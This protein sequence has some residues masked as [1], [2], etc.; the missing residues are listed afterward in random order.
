[1]SLGVSIVIC[2]HNSAKRLPETLRHLAMQDVGGDVPWEVLLIDNASTDG[3]ADLARSCWPGGAPAEIRIVSE[4]KPGIANARFR[5][6][7]EARHEIVSFLDDDNWAGPRWVRDVADFFERHP[8]A[9]AV[10]GPSVAAFE[11]TPPAWFD[12]IRG[13]YAVGSQ[14]A[15]A[16]DITM[17]PGTLLW[18]AGMSVRKERVLD[19]FAQGFHFLACGGSSLPLR[20]GEDTE[21]SFALRASGGRLFYEPQFRIEH[22]MPAGRLVWPRALAAAGTMGSSSVL[23]DI[24]LLALDGP[25]YAGRSPFKKS[26]AFYLA[27]TIADLLKLLAGHPWQ[28][29]RQPEGSLVALQFRKQRAR[30]GFILMLGARFGALKSQLSKSRWRRQNLELP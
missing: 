22:F 25:G 5:S 29:L 12:A 15:I 28:C 26:R 30:L 2:C 8:D 9:S 18:T 21:M 10:G 16:G 7:F 27:R 13:Y 6:F 17:E 23:I 3:T 19:L 14:H 1:M 4:P 24:Y 11:S 20:T